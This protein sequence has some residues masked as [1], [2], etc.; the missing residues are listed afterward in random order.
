M[1]KG[2]DALHPQVLGELE[3]EVDSGSSQPSSMDVPDRE[4]QGSAGGWLERDVKLHSSPVLEFCSVL[5]S[6][7]IRSSK[8]EMSQRLPS[9]H[10]VPSIVTGRNASAAAPAHCALKPCGGLAKGHPGGQQG[11]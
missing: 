11:L 7:W 2:P 9:S 5:S 10:Q 4:S 1:R 3:D 6:P 8:L